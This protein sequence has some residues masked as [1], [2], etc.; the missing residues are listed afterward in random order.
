MVLQ[1]IWALVSFQFPDLFTIDRTPWTSYQ[2]IARPPAKH[3]TTQ[4]QNKYIYTPNIH[5]LSGIRTHDHSTRASEDSSCAL[6]RSA[7]VTGKMALGQIIL[8]VHHRFPWQYHSI[9]AEFISYRA[10]DT[11]ASYSV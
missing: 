7:T 11:D 8:Q 5:A 6:Y 4:T 3:R 10:A 1:P 9:N 2:L